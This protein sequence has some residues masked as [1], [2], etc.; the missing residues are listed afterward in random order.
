[1]F[2]S[3]T[4]EV[5][6]VSGNLNPEQ[7]YVSVLKLSRRHCPY[8]HRRPSS[9]TTPMS[10]QSLLVQFVNQ[11]IT[12]VNADAV[13][14]KDPSLFFSMLSASNS[15]QARIFPGKIPTLK[16]GEIKEETRYI[17]CSC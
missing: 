6:Q 5:D 13:R 1:M 15:F 12:Q 8:R 16:E 11:S 14:L 17:T 7:H 10:F 3:L 2:P 4:D 9:S